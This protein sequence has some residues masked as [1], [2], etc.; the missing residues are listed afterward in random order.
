MINDLIKNTD[1]L[2]T[3]EMGIAR[4]ALNLQIDAD[5]IVKYCCDKI[6]SDTATIGRKGKN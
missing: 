6:L 2:H 4:V 3:T 5:S 1:K